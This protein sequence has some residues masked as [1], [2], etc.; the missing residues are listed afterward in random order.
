MR[1]RRYVGIRFA[2]M[3]LGMLY[4]CKVERIML[5]KVF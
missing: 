2:A 1:D 4:F 3:I 5:Y